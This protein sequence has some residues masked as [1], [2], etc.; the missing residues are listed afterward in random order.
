MPAV[1]AGADRRGRG[2]DLG[3]ASVADSWLGAGWFLLAVFSAGGVAGVL[4]AA[5]LHTARAD[6]PDEGRGDWSR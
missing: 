2:E 5:L 4:L 1:D 6:S 3:E